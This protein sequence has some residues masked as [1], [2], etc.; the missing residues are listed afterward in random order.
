[1]IVASLPVMEWLPNPIFSRATI[2][3]YVS[4][5]IRLAEIY[6][7]FVR[8]TEFGA[9][10]CVYP[11]Q[12]SFNAAAHKPRALPQRYGSAAWLAGRRSAGDAATWV[13]HFGG[14]TSRAG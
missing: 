6:V 12:V 1:M 4:P 11:T 7:P 10:L 5:T 9:C 14:G 3:A 2:P 8:H 13:S